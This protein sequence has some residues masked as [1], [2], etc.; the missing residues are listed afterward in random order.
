MDELHWADAVAYYGPELSQHERMLCVAG[1]ATYGLLGCHAAAGDSLRLA[2]REGEHAER[3]LIASTLWT[4][5]IAA[6]IAAARDP[7]SAPVL[8]LL[9]INRSPCA[10]CAHLLSSAL[11]A[12]HDRHPLGFER[13]AFVLASL[14]YYQGRRFMNGEPA[15]NV[16]PNER[17]RAVT[18][19]RA[20]QEMHDAGWRL[21]TL[22]PGT[23]RTRRGGEQAEAFA[24]L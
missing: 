17:S 6:A 19:D 23:G 18:T 2:S 24:R 12:L 9:M 4:R 5:D 20:L 1:N 16:R 10:H 13:H 8:V 3:R 21:C 11:H 14:G 22:V 7:R 15:P